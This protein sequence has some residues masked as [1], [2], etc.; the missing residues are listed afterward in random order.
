MRWAI[1]QDEDG[2]AEYQKVKLEPSHWYVNPST[3][4][5]IR[6]K[7]S[8]HR[9]NLAK[10][11]SNKGLNQTKTVEWY[12]WEINR[13]EKTIELLELMKKVSSTDGTSK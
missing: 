13:L 12:T 1:V 4:E 2:G 9:A 6:S 10:E 7:R 5:R 8:C 11:K 3:L